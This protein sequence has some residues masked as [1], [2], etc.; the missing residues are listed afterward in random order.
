[1]DEKYI[2]T[3]I[4][5]RVSF[6]FIKEVQ[7]AI[8]QQVP[9]PVNFMVTHWKDDPYTSMAYV[10]I[11]VGCSGEIFDDLAEMVDEKVHFAG[12]VCDLGFLCT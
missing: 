10:H 8:F 2:P 4:S 12:E 6:N 3:F 9:E 7:Y 1:M 11:P 5:F